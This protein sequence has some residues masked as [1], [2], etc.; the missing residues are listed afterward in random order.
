MEIQTSRAWLLFVGV[1][2]TF[3]SSHMDVVL[4]TVKPLVPVVL[5]LGHS[6]YSTCAWGP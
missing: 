6:D 4:H 2:R 3:Y 1:A 5:S